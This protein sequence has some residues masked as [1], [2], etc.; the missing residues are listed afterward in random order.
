MI[1]AQSTSTEARWPG[2]S[3]MAASRGY[4]GG[5]KGFREG[6][7]HGVVRGQVVSEL[8]NPSEE[9]LVRVAHRGQVEEVFQ[10]GSPLGRGHGAADDEA[11][12]GICHL[13]IQQVGNVQ[14]PIGEAPAGPDAPAG[15]FGVLGSGSYE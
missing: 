2:A 7:V 6:D 15:P 9:R 5:S 14:L 8:P 4:Q 3:K 11:P 10:R 13:Q 1:A 12:G